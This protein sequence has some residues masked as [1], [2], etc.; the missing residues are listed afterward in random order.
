VFFFIIQ[1]TL[2]PHNVRGGRWG[3][4]LK[5]QKR[6]TAASTCIFLLKSLAAAPLRLRLSPQSA[7]RSSKTASFRLLKHTLG[8]ISLEERVRAAQSTFFS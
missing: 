6:I 4:F 2:F 1:D 8:R 3:V 5:S 7:S